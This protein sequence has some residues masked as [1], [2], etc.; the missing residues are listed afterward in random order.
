[1]ASSQKP[2]LMDANKALALKLKHTPK[3]FDLSNL[4]SKDRSWPKAGECIIG[5]W[6]KIRADLL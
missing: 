4:S 5:N 3:N 6:R 2:A 1:M